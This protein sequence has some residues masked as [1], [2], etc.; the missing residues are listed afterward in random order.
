M[1]FD[2]GGFTRLPPRRI[3][4]EPFRSPAVVLFR[5]PWDHDAVCSHT[6]PR[7]EV[8]PL[9]DHDSRW[10]SAIAHSADKLPR[11]AIYFRSAVVPIQAPA[12]CAGQRTGHS[13]TIH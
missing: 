7:Q 10:W 1:T 8:S 2:G 11:H 4:G 5:V 12:D 13:W 9:N 6:E 3:V